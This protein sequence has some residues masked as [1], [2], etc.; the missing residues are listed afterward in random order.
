MKHL[1]HILLML[2]LIAQASN[3]TPTNP[4]LSQDNVDKIITTCN[5]KDLRNNS[6]QCFPQNVEGYSK[7]NLE[8]DREITTLNSQLIIRYIWANTLNIRELGIDTVEL[9]NNINYINQSLATEIKLT[10]KEQSSKDKVV[11]GLQTSKI[12]NLDYTTF[13]GYKKPYQYDLEDIE[14][15]KGKE[16]VLIYKEL[17]EK[18]K[19]NTI[20]DNNNCIS[21]VIKMEFGFPTGVPNPFSN[22]IEQ[23]ITNKYLKNMKPLKTKKEKLNFRMNIHII[24][25]FNSHTLDS[26]SDILYRKSENLNEI[27]N[28]GETDYE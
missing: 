9:G 1:K 2:P 28:T 8:K 12:I 5:L 21:T 11:N 26:N 18:I 7:S 13:Y 6:K 14:L 10:E 16:N 24:Y 17:N 23:Y 3:F 4:R 15:N 25:T 22:D 27:L 19:K 20:C